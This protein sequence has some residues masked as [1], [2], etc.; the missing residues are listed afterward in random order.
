MDPFEEFPGFSALDDPVIVG[1][2]QGEDPERTEVGNCPVAGALKFGRLVQRPDADDRALPGRV[3]GWGSSVVTSKTFPGSIFPSRMS[4]MS[5][6][7]YARTGACP[8]ATR[9]LCRNRL[10]M[11]I[12]ASWYWGTPTRLITPPGRTM[13]VACS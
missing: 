7:M 9:M 5:S 3:P 11:P 1:G 13:P 4:G 12:G 10:S 6:A 2:G 8:P